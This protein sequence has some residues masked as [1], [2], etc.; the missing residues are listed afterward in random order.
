MKGTVLQDKDLTTSQGVTFLPYH[1][2]NK[3]YLNKQ[4]AD[5]RVFG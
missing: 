2:E 5:Q 3:Y 1:S 4:A